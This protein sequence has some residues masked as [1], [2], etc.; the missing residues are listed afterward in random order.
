MIL[1]I[2]SL[3]VPHTKHVGK[4]LKTLRLHLSLEA[5]HV[6]FSHLRRWGLLTAFRLLALITEDSRSR[7]LLHDFLG[8]LEQG[9]QREDIMRGE[10][11][12]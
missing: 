4:E 2:H 7:Q 9:V 10:L 11:N 6:F 12:R 1:D 5:F 8:D 3:R